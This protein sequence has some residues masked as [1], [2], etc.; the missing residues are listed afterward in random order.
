MIYY[1]KPLHAHDAYK[2]LGYSDSDF[3]VAVEMSKKIL[4]LP[5]HTELDEDQLEH[6]CVK[7][8][9]FVTS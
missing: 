1:P 9:N 8:K 4:S 7:I 6:I 3:P 5:M 2:S